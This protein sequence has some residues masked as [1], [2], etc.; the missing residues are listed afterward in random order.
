MQRRETVRVR[1]IEDAGKWGPQLVFRL[2]IFFGGH[3][4]VPWGFAMNES[5]SIYHEL[6]F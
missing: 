3:R 2:L 4:Y 6:V 5:R 1:E